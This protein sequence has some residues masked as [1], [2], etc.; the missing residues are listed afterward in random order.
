M[1]GCTPVH[2]PHAYIRIGAYRTEKQYM[3]AIRVCTYAQARLRTHAYPC[4]MQSKHVRWRMYGC[5]PMCTLHA[6]TRTQMHMHVHAFT[7]T[8]HTYT[9]IQL[10]MYTCGLRMRHAHISVRTQVYECMP[11][12]PAYIRT[13]AHVYVMSVVNKPVKSNML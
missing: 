11:C 7:H 12:T 2:P 9:H 13:R 5:A 8:T 6:H 10:R 3:H 4:A 1:C